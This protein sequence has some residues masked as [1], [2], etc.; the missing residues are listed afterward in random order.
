MRR[1]GRCSI[2][3]C[4]KPHRARGW[5]T[6]HYARWQRQG[7]TIRRPPGTLWTPAE[8]RML[9]AVKLT[10]HT[11]RHRGEGAFAQVAARLGRTAGACVSRYDVLVRQRGHTTGRQWTGEGLWG[12]AEDEAILRALRDAGE[13]AVPHGTWPD[14]AGVLGRTVGAVRLRAWKLRH[15]LVREA[16]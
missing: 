12:K 7:D 13:D 10:P 1:R 6:K 8:D 9:L 2:K 5:C 16:A 3:G 15:G 11:E 4:G 14:L